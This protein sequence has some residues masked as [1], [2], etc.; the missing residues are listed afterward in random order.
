MLMRMWPEE[1]C[2]DRVNF[3]VVANLLAAPL[4][5]VCSRYVVLG[6][7]LALLWIRD[8]LPPLFVICRSSAFIMLSMLLFRCINGLSAEERASAAVSYRKL[9]K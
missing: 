3:A 9:R 6:R 4:E 7:L 1:L 2:I 5:V 8:L